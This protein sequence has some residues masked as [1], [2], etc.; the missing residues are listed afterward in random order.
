MIYYG[1]TREQAVIIGKEYGLTVDK[2]FLYKNL[3]CDTE[4][5]KIYENRVEIIKKKS[6]MQYQMIVN[7]MHQINMIGNVAIV[8][9]GWSGTIQWCLEEIINTMKE[10]IK[11][12]G[13]YLGINPHRVVSG[14][15]Y[16]YLYNGISKMRK[17]LLCFLGVIEAFFQSNE[18]TTIGYAGIEKEK[19]I[20][21]KAESEYSDNLKA[22]KALEN[23]QNG[24][25]QYIS[26]KG[27]MKLDGVSL[28]ESVDVFVKFGKNPT[29]K[30]T[31]MF[32][33]LFNLDGKKEYFLP[34]KPIFRYRPS[35]FMHALSKSCWKTGFMKAAFK[36]PLPYYRLYEMLRK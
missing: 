26:D 21:I 14:Q 19:V 11:V 9:V 5:K 31:R 33:F 15:V 2:Y 25:M 35:E 34:Q 23:V 24:A 29:L 20:P 32:S 4:L 10:D 13:Y 22:Q 8:D 30:E 18:G 36:I 6:K 16:G 27:Q 1:F 12:S 3:A 17:E 7:Y 28:H